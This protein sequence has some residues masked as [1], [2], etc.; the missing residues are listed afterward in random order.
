MSILSAMWRTTWPGTVHLLHGVLS[1]PF[2]SHTS[3]HM[4]DRQNFPELIGSKPL[5]HLKARCGHSCC[6]RKL[7]SEYQG[8]SRVKNCFQSCL[9]IIQVEFQGTTSCFFFMKK[10]STKKSETQKGRVPF[11]HVVHVEAQFLTLGLHKRDLIEP[12][13]DRTC[14]TEAS[15]AL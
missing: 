13:L 15:K 9:R 10:R 8:Y 3:G 14:G 1:I 4:H 6:H 7:D 11:C 5:R 2:L 12:F